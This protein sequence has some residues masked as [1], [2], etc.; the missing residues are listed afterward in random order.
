MRI[1]L[2]RAGYTPIEV[3]DYS[4]ADG[5]HQVETQFW[6]PSLLEVLRNKHSWNFYGI[7]KF[8]IKFFDFPASKILG[9]GGGL[10]ALA[11][12]KS[13]EFTC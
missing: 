6:Y 13:P 9:A 12:K 7:S 10:Y 5:V 8:L 3:S 2:E 11:R 1:L 4:F